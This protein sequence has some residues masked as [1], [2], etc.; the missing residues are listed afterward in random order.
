VERV[1]SNEEG[2]RPW[3]IETTDEQD[4]AERYS[5]TSQAEED[6]SYLTAREVAGVLLRR[7]NYDVLDVAV[8]IRSILYLPAHR[9]WIVEFDAII[10]ERYHRTLG[11]VFRSR[12]TATI[13]WRK[14]RYTHADE[15]LMRLPG[16]GK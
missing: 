5:W 12:Q 2:Q 14:G 3:T 1:M 8:S 11:D 7:P 16:E 13:E 15:V 4:Q 10:S 9:I 6:M